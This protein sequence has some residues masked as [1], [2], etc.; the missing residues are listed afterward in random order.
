MH[1][2]WFHFAHLSFPFSN[3]SFEQ[4]FGSIGFASTDAKSDSWLNPY[5]YPK[6]YSFM[7]AVQKSREKVEEN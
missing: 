1:A 3:Y 4:S 6:S 7:P 5:P 2:E